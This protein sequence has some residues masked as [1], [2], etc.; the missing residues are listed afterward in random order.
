LIFEHRSKGLILA[1]TTALCWA[2]LAIGLKKALVFTSSGNIVALRMLI[3]FL[4]LLIYF[5]I[6]KRNELIKIKKDFPFT[7]PLAGLLLALNFYGFM[8]GV[9][10][11]GAGNAQIMIQLGPILLI[12]SALILFKE[13]F[14]YKQL[15]GI[16]LAIAGF[17]LFYYDKK[18]FDIETTLNIGN[19]W[20]I[21]AAAV[22][23][24]YASLQ[25]RLTKKWAPQTLN[26]IVYSF[27]GLALSFLLD[28]NQTLNFTFSQ[29]VLI[30][31]LGLNTIIAYG[32]FAEALK[33]A[34]ASEVSLVITVNP[35]GT[36]LLLWLGQTLS[37]S[38]MPSEYITWMGVLGALCVVF[39]VGWTL[40]R[41][42]S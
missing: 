19:L 20:L 18:Q 37:I 22:W 9:E 24:I 15:F 21:V 1:G 7:A 5:S 3:S 26:L 38:W 40:T 36:L 39:G 13:H 16:L 29:W 25:K 14:S 2:V 6:F 11:T 12:A 33:F 31:F 42:K 35:L 23:A 8:K 27:C 10:F 28:V 32:C 17:T 30:L 4:S 34:P 41:K